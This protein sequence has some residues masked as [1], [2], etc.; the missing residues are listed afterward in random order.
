M[1]S[2]GTLFFSHSRGLP[3][4]KEL[5][6]FRELPPNFTI[7]VCQTSGK[8]I[9]KHCQKRKGHN[10]VIPLQIIWVFTVVY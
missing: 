8:V 1:E 6:L 7:T 4:R 3:V 9:G 2:H 10:H 5:C